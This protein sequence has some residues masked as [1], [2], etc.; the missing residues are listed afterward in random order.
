M[1]WQTLKTFIVVKLALSFIGP[2]KSYGLYYY[3][4][5]TDVFNVQTYF[6]NCHPIYGYISLGI[7]FSSYM[8][9]VLFLTFK[10]NEQ[11]LHAL[12]Y[13]VYHIANIL[14]KIRKN[15][16]AILTGVPLPE[17]KEEDKIYGHAVTFL[18]MCS[19]SIPYFH[20]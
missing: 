12:C 18:E 1:L 11:F 10:R 2:I 9:T 3:D 14:N 13:P 20:H 5:Y 7:L 15:N 17:D 16:N 4:L 19:E 8:S 6:K